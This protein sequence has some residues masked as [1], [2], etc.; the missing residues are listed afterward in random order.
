MPAFQLGVCE[1]GFPMPGPYAVRT[2]A[3]YGFSGMELDFGAYEKAYPLSVPAVQRAYLEMAD[4]Y[5]MDFPSMTID[6][7][8]WYGLS[9]PLHSRNGMIAFDGIRRGIEAAAAMGIPV[10][11]LPSFNDGAIRNETDFHNTCE[12]I[13]M[14]C[15][16]ARPLG[17]TIASEN[18][19]SAKDTQRMVR[20]VGYG[21]FGIMFDTQ[22][23]FLADGRD[24]AALL[25]EIHPYVVQVHLKDGYN[26]KLSG[27]VL[28]T[29]ESGF[30]RTAEAIKETA[31]TQWLLLE[32]YY[33]TQPM[34]NLDS[35]PFRILEKDLA[36]VREVFDIQQPQNLLKREAGEER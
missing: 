27:S 28:G 17:I 7:L 9:R 34:S 26:G 6:S 19:L 35:D 25:R 32:N 2:A 20:E 22:N 18:T 16:I 1:W 36:V 31:C 24:T 8:N 13:K 3:E 10:I 5:G 11:Q 23:Y 29:G 4:A 21:N 33:H 30:F 14:A 12:K 15:E